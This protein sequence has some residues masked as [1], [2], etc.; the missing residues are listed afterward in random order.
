MILL[1]ARWLSGVPGARLFTYI[2][3]RAALA[4]IIAFFL[5]MWLGPRVIAKLR[6]LGFQDREKDD[7]ARLAQ[8]WRQTDKKKTPTMG[9][10]FLVPSIMGAVVLCGDLTSVYVMVGLA[11]ALWYMGIGAIDD[12][13]K[14]HRRKQ[15]GLSRREKLLWQTVGALAAVAVLYWY[16]TSTG[17]SSLLRIYVPFVKNF[18]LDLPAW[19][20]GGAVVYAAFQWFTL[21]GTGNAVNIT[22]GMDGLA[23]GCALVAGISLAVLCYVAGS[24]RLADY[25]IVPTIQGAAEMSI[26]A[27]AL[28]GGCL[29][30]LWF[31]CYPAQVFMG[32]TGSLPLGAMLGYLA[33]VSRQ[34]LVLPVIAGIFVVEAGSSYL[35]IVWFK[36]TGRR[37][38]PIAPLHHVFQLRQYP[39]PKIVIRF[40][41][42]AALLSLA[43]VALLK[44]R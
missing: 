30:F 32:D 35:Q 29:G 43:G 38:F 6:E 4:A 40:W 24:P 42:A 19:G 15:G 27:A 18:A 39:E 26:L 25:F 3:F 34:E 5:C 21:V 12:W 2:T 31:N 36:R 9:G 1:L 16:A 23:A 13:A 41:I 20:L 44:I 37:L 10:V 7:D 22:D 14:L 17:R 33:L 8:I 28:V 11:L